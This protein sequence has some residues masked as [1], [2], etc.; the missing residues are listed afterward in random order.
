[1]TVSIAARV[2]A[3][4]TTTDHTIGGG[5]GQAAT[6]CAADHRSCRQARPARPA[7]R[8]RIVDGAVRSQ[9]LASFAGVSKQ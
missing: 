9:T 2:L 4:V 3:S 8:L 5:T 1:M 7:A 6:A